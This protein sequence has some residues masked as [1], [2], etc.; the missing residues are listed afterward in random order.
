MK[1]NVKDSLFITTQDIDILMLQ[2]HPLIYPIYNTFNFNK[3]TKNVVKDSI[4]RE[5]ILKV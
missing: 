5:C 4:L 2:V 1:G 3:I